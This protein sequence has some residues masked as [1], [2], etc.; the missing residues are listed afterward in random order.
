M[1]PGCNWCAPFWKS[2]SAGN[3][4]KRRA[5][6]I[7]KKGI[8]RAG[9]GS[10]PAYEAGLTERPECL[11]GGFPRGCS[12]LKLLLFQRHAVAFQAA[13]STEKPFARA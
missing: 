3:L 1:Q 8:A 13:G 11:L 4:G 6:F 7:K 2:T 12:S 9:R 10:A 5:F